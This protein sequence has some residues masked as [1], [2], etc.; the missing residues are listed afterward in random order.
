M[1]FVEPMDVFDAG[2]MLFGADPTGAAFGVWQ[3][4]RHTGAQLA[5]EPSTFV[6]EEVVTPNPVASQT[7]YSAVFGWKP[8]PAGDGY[9]GQDVGNGPM[10][11]LRASPDETSPHWVTYFAVASLADA[12]AKV[13]ELGGAGSVRAER[14]AIRSTAEAADTQD[15]RFSM[16]QLAPPEAS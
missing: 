4:K 13:R 8:E 2:R 14:N 7:F 5:N 11:G 15:A 12:L 3:A 10:A 1:L 6:W 9:W 16:I